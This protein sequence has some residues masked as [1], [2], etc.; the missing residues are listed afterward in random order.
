MWLKPCLII[1]TTKRERERNRREERRKIFK[2]YAA[3]QQVFGR[4]ISIVRWFI[5]LD[6]KSDLWGHNKTD[7]VKIILKSYKNY[8]FLFSTMTK[9]CFFQIG[10]S[11]T[12]FKFFV[13][14]YDPVALHWCGLQHMFSRCV[15]NFI[16]CWIFAYS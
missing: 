2:T 7:T 10:Y 4:K 13:A 9:L 11:M 6:S 3:S 16:F 14:I 15:G 1:R 12:L 5:V 8:T